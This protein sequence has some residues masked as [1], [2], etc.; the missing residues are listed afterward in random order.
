MKQNRIKSVENKNPIN[1]LKKWIN[2]I[3]DEYKI[4]QLEEKENISSKQS[5]KK[6]SKDNQNNSNKRKIIGY[7]LYNLEKEVKHPKRVRVVLDAIPKKTKNKFE[8]EFDSKKR[9]FDNISD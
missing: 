8:I 3:K 2:K 6:I 9:C 4:L 1:K 7:N 5:N